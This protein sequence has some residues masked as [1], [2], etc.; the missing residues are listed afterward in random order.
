MGELLLIGHDLAEKHTSFRR[1]AEGN[2]KKKKNC[3]WKKSIEEDNNIGFY[4]HCFF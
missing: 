3:S 2:M 4:G 1:A